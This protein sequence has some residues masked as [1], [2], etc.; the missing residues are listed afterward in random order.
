MIL[1]F[2]VST[3]SVFENYIDEIYTEL[4]NIHPRSNKKENNLINLINQYANETD[5]EKRS[6]LLE[7]IKA[8]NFYVSSAEKIDYVIS[9]CK[10]TGQEKID[11]L[12]LIRYYRS[13]RNTI[14][15]LGINKGKPISI[16]ID[17]IEIRMDAN[18]PSYT[19]DHNSAFHACRKLMDIYSLITTKTAE[20]TATPRNT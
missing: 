4:I 12:E 5:K 14:H 15:N 7:K 18:S 16:N 19:S 3:F 13:Q 11:T 1:D 9:S 6:F 8:I 17:E 10:L 2:K 20:L